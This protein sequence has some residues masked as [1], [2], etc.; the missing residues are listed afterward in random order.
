MTSFLETLFFSF[1][2]K[3]ALAL[4]GMSSRELFLL[5]SLIIMLLVFF[6]S[7]IEFKNQRI[8]YVNNYF[9]R[10]SSMTSLGPKKSL[11]KFKNNRNPSEKQVVPEPKIVS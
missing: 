5:F 11:L 2:V 1:I 9:I 4:V 10:V 3:V 6:T 8:I 7:F